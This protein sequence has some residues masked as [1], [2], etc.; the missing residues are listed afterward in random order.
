VQTVSQP[1]KNPSPAPTSTPFE[2]TDVLPKLLECWKIEM[3]KRLSEVIVYRLKERHESSSVVTK[4]ANLGYQHK[5][6]V[7][8]SL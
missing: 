4:I 7:A 1:R 6:Y 2:N 3:L 5:A 8:D